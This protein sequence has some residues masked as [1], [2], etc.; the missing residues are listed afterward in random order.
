VGFPPL[1][2]PVVPEAVP[3]IVKTDGKQQEVHIGVGTPCP[4][5]QPPQ[6]LTQS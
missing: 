5:R 2:R 6:G 1:T 3:I 4:G